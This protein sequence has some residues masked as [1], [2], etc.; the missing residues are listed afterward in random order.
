MSGIATRTHQ[1]QKM[2]AHTAAKVMDTRKTSPNSRIIEK[3]A[4]SIGGG[5]NHRFALYDMVMLKD[6]HI[7]Y[8]G[9]ITNALSACR[10][11]L[12]EH[13]LNL[14]VEVETRNLMELEEALASGMAD[15]IM[16]DNYST[17]DMQEAVIRTGGRIPLEASGN[18]RENT[19]VEVAET[20]VDFIS[21]GA[22]THSYKSLDLS[23]KAIRK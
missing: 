19:I 12:K 9:G 16:L 2:I 20:G 23:L 8:A 13:N 22:L 4:V 21:I 14:K 10:S 18:I 11:Y 5:I 7:D 6:N 15:V 17:A 3:W 1:L